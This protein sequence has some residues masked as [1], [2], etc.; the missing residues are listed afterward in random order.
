MS[1]TATEPLIAT[2]KAHSVPFLTPQVVRPASKTAVEVGNA[3]VAAE[4]MFLNKARTTCQTT[5]LSNLTLQT[6]TRWRMSLALALQMMS[7]SLDLQMMRTSL[8]LREKT[9]SLAL[10]EKTM[11]MMK[12]KAQ[13]RDLAFT[14][15]L[16]IS[17]ELEQL[18][19][20]STGLRPLVIPA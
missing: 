4:N 12:L 20:S 5:M 17:N 10:Q 9:M 1:W 18:L 15:P 2:T 6:I 16:R 8:A 19:P 13:T 11:R 14:S 7:L 3:D